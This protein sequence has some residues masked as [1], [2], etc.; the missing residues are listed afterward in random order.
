LLAHIRGGHGWD[1]A[2][3]RRH[4]EHFVV[5]VGVVEASGRDD[6]LAIWIGC[7]R[8]HIRAGG[9]DASQPIAYGYEAT[10]ACV[11]MSI[12]E[13]RASKSAAIQVT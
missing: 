12:V 5:N 11:I 4:G 2:D 10:Y 1:I 8:L 7:N 13:R 6:N 3:Q 9:P